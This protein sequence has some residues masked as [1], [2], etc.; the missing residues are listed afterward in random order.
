MSPQK[1]NISI[2]HNCEDHLF[3]WLKIRMSEHGISFDQQSNL[4]EVLCNYESE[5]SFLRQHIKQIQQWNKIKEEC[6]SLS[7]ELNGYGEQDENFMNLVEKVA[8]DGQILWLT[9]QEN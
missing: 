8:F 2:I 3:N 7:S 9:I 1:R 6:Y 5:L 4:T